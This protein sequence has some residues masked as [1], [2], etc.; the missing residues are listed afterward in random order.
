MTSIEATEILLLTK[1][2]ACLEACDTIGDKQGLGPRT[3]GRRSCS[4]IKWEQTPAL[5]FE[6]SAS[7]GR[8]RGTALPCPYVG[9]NSLKK[10]GPK[11]KD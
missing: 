11:A 4:P 5:V 6:A 7:F 3:K 1:T 9:L 8:S 10:F 2:V